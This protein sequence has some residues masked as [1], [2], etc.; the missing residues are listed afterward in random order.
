MSIAEKIKKLE[1]EP[2][3][4]S[5]ILSPTIVLLGPKGYFNENVTL[6]KQFTDEQEIHDFIMALKREG[7]TMHPILGYK[8]QYRAWIEKEVKLY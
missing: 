4:E 3:T 7:K 6:G 5:G 1:S 8:I 2:N